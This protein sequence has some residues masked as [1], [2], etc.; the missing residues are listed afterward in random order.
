MGV[1]F[2]ALGSVTMGT[3]ALQD[4][5]IRDAVVEALRGSERES[6]ELLT[7]LGKSG[8]ADSDIRTAVSELIHE[9]KIELTSHRM[10]RIPI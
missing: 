7:F 8:Y 1:A 3:V 6:M 4:T 2:V 10:L 5:N 9:G